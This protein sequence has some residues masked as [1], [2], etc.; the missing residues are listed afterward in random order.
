MLTTHSNIVTVSQHR[1]SMDQSLG[2]QQL[3]FR[4]ISNKNKKKRVCTPTPK[5]TETCQLVHRVP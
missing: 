5:T 3:E 4:Q 1:E 2:A